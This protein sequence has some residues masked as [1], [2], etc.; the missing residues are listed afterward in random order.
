MHSTPASTAV[1][2]TPTGGHLSR[3]ASETVLWNET[4]ETGRKQ[5]LA[6]CSP[7]NQSHTEEWEDTG[8]DRS[9]EGMGRI[10]KT[11]LDTMKP[12]RGEARIMTFGGIH[13]K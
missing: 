3:D 12:F 5:N 2:Q 10:L 7:R 8:Q 9:T 4:P 13:R 11:Y 6:T 1:P